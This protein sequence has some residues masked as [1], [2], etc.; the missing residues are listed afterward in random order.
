MQAVKHTLCS[1]AHMQHTGT[2]QH[3]NDDVWVARS[4]ANVSWGGVGSTCLHYYIGCDVSPTNSNHVIY[5]CGC[6]HEVK[7]VEG[8]KKMETSIKTNCNSLHTV[9]TNGC[10][11]IT[12]TVQRFG[13]LNAQ[14]S[15]AS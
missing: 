3:E 4:C 12:K 5:S 9:M 10:C 6:S 7:M 14:L 15:E 2:Q 11:F 8:G 1:H 13:A